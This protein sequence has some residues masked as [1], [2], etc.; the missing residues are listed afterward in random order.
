MVCWCRV[1]ACRIPQRGAQIKV[2]KKPR[3]LFFDSR[4]WEKNWFLWPMIGENWQLVSNE[5]V[6]VGDCREITDHFRGI[7]IIY[8][9]LIK[10]DR[11]MWTCNNWLDLPTLGS[12]KSPWS[13]VAE[14]HLQTGPLKSLFLLIGSLSTK[15]VS[16]LSRILTYNEDSQL[17]AFGSLSVLQIRLY[18]VPIGKMV[19]SDDAHDVSTQNLNSIPT[20]TCGAPMRTSAMRWCLVLSAACN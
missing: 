16:D 8:P 3:V 10:E 15:I 2:S 14:Y 11:R 5:T 18:T 19:V 20:F 17:L 7:F 9:K 4:G 12:Q 6:E 13:H 1:G